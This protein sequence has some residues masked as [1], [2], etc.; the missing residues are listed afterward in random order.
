[1]HPD[2][3]GLH[4]ANA[5]RKMESICVYIAALMTHIAVDGALVEIYGELL[6]LR[7]HYVASKF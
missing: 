2:D 5:Q 3:P 1:M 6:F 7:V 4:L